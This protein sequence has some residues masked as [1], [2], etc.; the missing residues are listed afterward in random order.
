MQ[1]II[2]IKNRFVTNDNKTKL[3]GGWVWVVDKIISSHFIPVS[4]AD[5]IY[6]LNFDKLDS[7]LCA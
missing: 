5:N 1:L 6:N 2:M 7:E 4:Y 3:N